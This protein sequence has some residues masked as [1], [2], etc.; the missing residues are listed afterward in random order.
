MDT[1]TNVK[2][3]QPS[4]SAMSLD[5]EEIQKQD[6]KKVEVEQVLRLRGGNIGYSNPLFWSADVLDVLAMSAAVVATG[7]IPGFVAV[8]SLPV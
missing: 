8:K 7:T 5:P 2:T 6:L 1:P 4:T 3:S